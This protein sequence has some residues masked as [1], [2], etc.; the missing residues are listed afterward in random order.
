M[1]TLG[2]HAM[3]M[4]WG[5]GDEM[6]VAETNKII[7]SYRWLLALEVDILLPRLGICCDHGILQSQLGSR[8]LACREI[9]PTVMGGG[10]GQKVGWHK[11]FILFSSSQDRHDVQLFQE[12]YT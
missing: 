2:P 6:A 4:A 3:A 12:T 8:G 11:G 9:M 5:R 10:S 1:A 7:H